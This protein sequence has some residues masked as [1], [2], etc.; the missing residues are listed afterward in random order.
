MT[1][2]AAINNGLNAASVRA[3]LYW[4]FDNGFFEEYHGDKKGER[5]VI[6]VKTLRA[7][8]EPGAAQ[9]FKP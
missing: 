5:I 7:K 9:I 2:I 4:F 3:P 1:E 8:T 6:S